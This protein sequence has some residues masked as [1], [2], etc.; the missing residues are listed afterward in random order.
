M[1]NIV[2]LIEEKVP[3]HFFLKLKMVSLI[4]Q[5]LCSRV[6]FHCSDYLFD[7]IKMC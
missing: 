2:I 3:Q 7:A 4:M 1:I 5:K 6:G